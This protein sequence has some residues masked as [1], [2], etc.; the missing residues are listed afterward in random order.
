MF[1][2]LQGQMRSVTTVPYVRIIDREA[3]PRQLLLPPCESE[4]ELC[5]KAQESMTESGVPT[6]T[7]MDL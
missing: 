4:L 7:R 2:A 5:R 1:E 6:S 3:N